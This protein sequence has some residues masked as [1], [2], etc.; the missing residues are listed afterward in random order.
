MD[1]VRVCGAVLYRDGRILLGRRSP[2]RL[3]YPGVWDLPGGHCEAR[4]PPDQAIARELR[5]EIRVT[6][7]ALALLAAVH[8][9]GST[10]ETVE[11]VVYLVTKWVGEPHNLLPAEHDDL[12]WVGVDEASALALASPRYPKLFRQ[13]ERA[14]WR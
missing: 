8:L 13:A 7:V 3:S 9:P 14:A 6:P 11:Y 5:E 4:E 2:N 10:T 1:L 12:A